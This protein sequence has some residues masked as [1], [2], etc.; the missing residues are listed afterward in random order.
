MARKKIN[1]KMN[2]KRQKREKKLKK[3]NFFLNYPN[4]IKYDT[5]QIQHNWGKKKKQEENL[6]ILEQHISKRHP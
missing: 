3:K 2:W 5:P 6:N 4:A 1:D